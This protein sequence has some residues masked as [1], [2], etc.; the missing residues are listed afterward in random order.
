M[1]FCSTCFFTLGFVLSNNWWNELALL[2]AQLLF[3]IGDRY[4]NIRILDSSLV[5]LLCTAISGILMGAQPALMIAAAAC[6]F[7]IW[8]MSRQQHFMK[9]KTDDHTTWAFENNHTK[10]LAISVGSGLFVSEASFLLQITIPFGLIFFIV[11]G[12]LFCLFKF[13]QLIKNS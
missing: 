12:V 3:F 9:N 2:I 6:V 8:D 11:S 5:V 4:Q 13:F 7:F 10:M 1:F